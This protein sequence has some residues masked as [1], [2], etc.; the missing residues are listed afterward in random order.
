MF[1]GHGVNRGHIE[2]LIHKE[3]A[4][5]L[6]GASHTVFRN[7]PKSDHPVVVGNPTLEDDP[8]FDRHCDDQ[9]PTMPPSVSRPTFISAV[10]TPA[11]PMLA[12]MLSRISLSTLKVLEL[13]SVMLL[14]R[15]IC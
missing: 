3:L 1:W 7:L 4:P 6:P 10:G 12:A 15:Y 11:L 13:I 8:A 2:I 9:G 14:R 5:G